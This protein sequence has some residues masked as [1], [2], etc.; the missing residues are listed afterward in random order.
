MSKTGLL[1]IAAFLIIVAGG[2]YVTQKGK[3]APQRD[4]TSG[5][6]QVE[7]ERGM[8]TLRGNMQDLMARQGSWKCAFTHAT[9]AA[10]STGVVYISNGMMRGNFVSQVPQMGEVK[11]YMIARD[12]FIYTWSDV[13][14]QGVKLPMTSAQASAQTQGQTNFYAQELDYNCVSWDADASPFTVPASV[15]FME[16]GQ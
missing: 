12:G 3:M 13:M 15:T 2:I 10:N 1:V 8:S 5:Q 16:L 9:D 14:P 7:Q 11:S 4:R 6:E